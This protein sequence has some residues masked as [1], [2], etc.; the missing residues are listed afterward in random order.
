MELGYFLV[1]GLVLRFCQ[2][3]ALPNL[4]FESYAKGINHEAC[5]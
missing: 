4:R 1:C 2:Y 5:M 3:G